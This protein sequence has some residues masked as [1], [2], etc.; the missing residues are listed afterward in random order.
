MRKSFEVLLSTHGSHVYSKLPANL[1][2][3][4]LQCAIS[5]ASENRS[6]GDQCTDQ[7]PYFAPRPLSRLRARGSEIL[8][9]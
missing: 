8:T 6:A 5:L 7:I 2:H 4:H 1:N 9:A 3:P